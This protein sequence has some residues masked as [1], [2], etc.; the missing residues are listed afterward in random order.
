MALLVALATTAG[1]TENR[2]KREVRGVWLTSYLS[3]WPGV[4]NDRNVSTVQRAA[5]VLLDTLRDNNMNVI[6][7]HVR[8]MCDALY[9]SSYEPWS[10][11]VSGTRG[12]APAFDPLEFL[13]DEA[14]KRGIE[15][16]AWVNPYRYSPKNSSWG[17][18]ELD[19]IHTHPE[20]LM[21]T[22]YE[23]VL[24]PGIPE[25][26]QRVVDVCHEIVN[27]YDVDGLVFDDYFYN[28]GGSSFDLDSI[29][30]N[31]YKRAGG[32][33]NQGDWRREN[34]NQ[35]VA[36]VCQMV[37]TT[38]P[39]VRFGIGPAGVACS[40]PSVAASYGVEPC[41]GSDWQYN[42]IYSDPM[43][44]VTRGTID[45]ISPQVYW[46]T[47][48]TYT[49]ITQWWGM[50]GKKFNRHVYISGYAVES[51]KDA[52]TVPEYLTELDIM[53]GAMNP[54]AWGTVYFRYTTWRRLSQ[55][56]DGKVT[57]LRH[58]LKRNAYAT[59]SLP[60]IMSWRLPPRGYTT[61]SGMTLDG[62]TLRW[63]PIDN[64]RYIVYA[65]PDSVADSQFTCQPEYMLGMTYDT[66]F[67][68]KDAYQNGYRYAVTI[69]DRWCYEYAPLVLGA[70]AAPAAKPTLLAPADG[71]SATR[72]ARLQWTGE[73]GDSYTVEFFSDAQLTN[74]VARAETQNTW[75]SLTQIGQLPDTGTFYWRVTARGLNR[76]DTAS[77]V[78]QITL[79]EFK[80]T[81]PSDGQVDVSLTP[82]LAWGHA[83]DGATYNVEISAKNTMVNPVYTATSAT[84]TFTVPRYVLGGA[85]EY[86]VRVTAHLGADSLVSNVSKL[87]TVEV[88]PSVP[89][90]INPSTDGMTL[91]GNSRVEVQPVEGA[92]NLRLEISANN[93]F[94]ARSSY[95][96]TINGGEFWSPQLNTITGVGK[97]N[98]G[99][100]YY[101]RARFAYLTLATGAS[102][103]FTEYSPIISFVYHDSMA[104]DVN[105][106]G[107][108]D[109]NDLNVLINI[110]LGKDSAS[111]YADRAN[112]DG[113]GDIDG[114]DLN[115][116]INIILGK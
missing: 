25:V 19:Y 62:D 67:G 86:F 66:A 115:Q 9:Q 46:N 80:I 89:V 16:Y 106:D 60:P 114:N 96:G 17:Q 73:P 38:K 98:D 78:R 26:R 27:N 63:Q 57:P 23:T 70:T 1:A 65:I 100:T 91:Y 48:Q 42:Q 74:L 51:V 45:F 11:Y 105:G 107:A 21:T 85:R 22:D 112:V 113:V 95:R 50:V 75:L 43:A 79:Q 110:I 83:A 14:H 58:Y 39:W 28:Q 68:I 37:H 94:P 41:P 104:G 24:N 93:T 15:I 34:V 81:A 99:V 7:F 109:G 55:T 5:R 36:D 97:L 69:F 64:V 35:M 53:R 33:M 108:V 12:V 103:Q 10:S 54:E 2:V 18:S 6:Y 59:P 87:R 13:V 82:E 101:V 20:W 56:L 52:W 72:L 29:Q 111:N 102:A 44:W 84:T 32:T 76:Y 88:I 47:A 31:A 8:A 4:I 77:D 90:V 61:V 116:L 30:Y 3:E 49:G 92:S 40:S 71:Q